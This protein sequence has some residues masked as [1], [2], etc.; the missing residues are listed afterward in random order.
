MSSGFL[1]IL[2][3]ATL[4]VVAPSML[5]IVAAWRRGGVPRIMAL[6]GLITLSCM[7]GLFLAPSDWPNTYEERTVLFLAAWGMIF[8][9]IAIAIFLLTLV[10]CI[11]QQFCRNNQYVS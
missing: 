7:A 2:L 9:L 4:L 3:V 6:V 10:M 8:A 5:L 1:V 11:Y